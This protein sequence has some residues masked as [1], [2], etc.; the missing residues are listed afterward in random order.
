[1]RC[2]H[3]DSA[4]ALVTRCLPLPQWRRNP[5][6]SKSFAI[7]TVIFNGVI[8]IGPTGSEN[9]FSGFARGSYLDDGTSVLK[10][11]TVAELDEPRADTQT[12]PGD[13]AVGC[14]ALWS[15]FGLESDN[16]HL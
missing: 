14:G 16:A 1:V 5:A 7:A 9:G 10:F 15:L 12:E 2:E 11:N 6:Q 13:K 3:G 4:H 8:T